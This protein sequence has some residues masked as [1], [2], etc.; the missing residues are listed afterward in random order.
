MKETDKLLFTPG[1]LNTSETVKNAMQF[2]FG[3][4]DEQ[5]IRRVAEIRKE[6]LKVAGVS[7][8]DFSAIPMQGSGTFGIESV[9]ASVVGPGDSLFVLV[10][11]TYGRRITQIADVLGVS[12]D[13]IECP[14]NE[15]HDVR[16]VE[17]ALAN[18]Q[19]THLAV[20]HCETTSGILNPIIGYGEL[21]KTFGCQFIVDAMSSFGGVPLEL[22][23][24][25]I[26]YLISSSNKCLQGV[27]G[28]AF[29]IARHSCLA[30]VKHQPKTLSL[31]LLDQLRTLDESGQ[32]RFT[33]PTHAMLAF[34]QALIEL[35]QEGGVAQRASRYAENHQVL[36]D[37]MREI[38]FEEFVPTELQSDII[39]SFLYPDD[40][41][42]DF[43]V[44]YRRLS[45]QGMLIYPGK[46]SVVDCFRIGNI[47]H[48]YPDDIRS[49]LD[50]IRQTL[51][52]MQI[53]RTPLQKKQQRT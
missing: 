51:D 39:T 21:A 24:S 28:F 2:D 36:I 13:S 4:R 43:K 25:N 38:G 29:V 9:I 10:N 17:Q 5:F 53:T 37:G 15:I 31:N 23:R 40:Q 49:L 30:R 7:G 26:D 16:V 48:L 50:A 12:Y 41:R 19:F 22:N 1:P 8:E 44:F 18:G 20:V 47:G 35:E 33:P 11:G 45:E 14:E 27:P 34:H 42:F 46:L 6:L 3:S 32:F 52:E